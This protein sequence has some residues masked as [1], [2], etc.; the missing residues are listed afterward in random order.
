[1][2]KIKLVEPEGTYL[3]W[4]DCS[5][6]GLDAGGLERFVED[7]AKLWVDFG[8]IFGKESGQFIRLNIACPRA[9]LKQALTQLKAAY[10]QT[11]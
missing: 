4:L 11:M 3:V 7:K 6:L 1:M 8:I 2:P 9:N 10:C 5:E